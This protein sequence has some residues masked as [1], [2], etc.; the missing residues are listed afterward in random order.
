[1]KDSAT[2]PKSTAV[3]HGN[4]RRIP[5][6]TSAE[7][8]FGCNWLPCWGK[9]KTNQVSFLTRNGAIDTLQ[10]AISRNRRAGY[11]K[12]SISIAS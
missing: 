4:C 10:I 8:L 5:A 12:Q 9:A 3:L 6:I 1:M 2:P 11:D 7:Q